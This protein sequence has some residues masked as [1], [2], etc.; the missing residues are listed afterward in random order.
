ML[1]RSNAALGPAET[2]QD[3]GKGNPIF[4]CLVYE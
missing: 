1:V 2:L 4:T 3:Y